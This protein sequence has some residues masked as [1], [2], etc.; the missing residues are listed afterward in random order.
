MLK[1]VF[2]MVN[3]SMLGGLNSFS[4]MP[5]NFFVKPVF[6]EKLL[7]YTFTVLKINV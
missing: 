7:S 1:Q 3:V 6:K 5:V 4:C 2:E